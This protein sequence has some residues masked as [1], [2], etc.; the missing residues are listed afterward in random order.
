MATMMI[1]LGC[2]V[3]GEYTSAGKE[4][5]VIPKVLGKELMVIPKV[6]GKE[7]MVIPKVLGKEL[8]VIPK[9]NSNPP[10]IKEPEKTIYRYCLEKNDLGLCDFFVQF[11]KTEDKGCGQQA[12]DTLFNFIEAWNDHSKVVKRESIYH[13]IKLFAQQFCKAAPEY[14][15]WVAIILIVWLAFCKIF[16]AI[17]HISI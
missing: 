16:N 17:E 5:M 12:C 4:L 14:L 7:L 1:V 15:A 9:E 3:G 11:T 6:L 2:E 8:M 13:H 10:E